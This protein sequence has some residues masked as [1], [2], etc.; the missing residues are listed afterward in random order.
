M[1]DPTD[2]EMDAYLATGEPLAVATVIAHEDP[3]WVGR[4][5]A[6]PS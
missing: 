3:D 5:I 4:R 2:E 6:L 1:G